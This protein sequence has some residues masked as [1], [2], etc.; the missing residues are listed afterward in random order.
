MHPWLARLR[1]DLVKR[2]LWPA[3]DLRE[4]LERSERPGAAELTALRDG[5]FALQDDEGV[6]CDARLLWA[7]LRESAPA[8]IS[9]AA[10]DS[11]GAGVDSAMNAVA[12]A[13]SLQADAP[14]APPSRGLGDALDSVLALE[15]L[16]HALEE[17]LDKN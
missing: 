5:L 7:R 16:F 17:S 4:L 11:F 1:H 2:A 12:H 10:L 8:E 6:A 9:P 13:V 15:R 3:R 14:R